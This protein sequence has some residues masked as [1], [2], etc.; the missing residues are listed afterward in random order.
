MSDSHLKK[1]D[2]GDEKPK[3]PAIT[4]RKFLSY[5][6]VLG[7]SPFIGQLQKVQKKIVS[8]AKIYIQPAGLIFNVLRPDDLLCLDFEFI[9]FKV[10]NLP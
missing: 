3:T 6:G 8:Q 9:N 4:R 10:L 1:A 5:A 7:A 2:R